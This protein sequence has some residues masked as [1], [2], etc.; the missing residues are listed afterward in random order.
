MFTPIHRALGIEPGAIT[1]DLIDA[2]VERKVEETSDLD[3]KTSLYDPR[4]PNWQDEVAKD[5]A[6][7][8]NSGGGWI[9]FGVAEGGEANG[10]A[11]VTPVE[12]N[13]AAQQ[14]ILQAAYARVGPPVLGL[15]FFPV[16]AGEGH[17]VL[18]RVPDS[19]DAPH[20]ARKGD[21]AFVA[22]RRNGPHTVFMSDREI[23]RSF[24]ERF[25]RSDD[26]EGQLQALFEHAGQGLNP[27][28]GIIIVMAALPKEPVYRANPLTEEDVYRFF[29]KPTLAGLVYRNAQA[30]TRW[31]SSRIRKGFRQWLQ[32]SEDRDS[33]AFRK[34]VHDDGTVLAAYRLGGLTDRSEAA[35]YYPVGEPNHCMSG[36]IESALIDFITTLRA[37]ATES[38]S[39][40]G[41]RVR[42]GLVGKDDE[43]IFVRTTEGGTN[44]LLDADYTEPIH[45]FQPV[46]ADLEP[47]EPMD[48]LLPVVNDLARDVINQGGVKHLKVMAEPDDPVLRQSD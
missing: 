12:W 40:A 27:E 11:Q 37:H 38:Q 18:V 4:K 21:D 31:D 44:F 8:A 9:V 16:S 29:R 1:R 20:F 48:S 43:P 5:V 26:R 3:W 47:L 23:E 13:A 28:Q 35:S 36:D 34:S 45:H 32:R 25:Q 33:R 24:R 42:V 46:T 22:P 10:A 17:V 6:A 7:M 19:P 41:Y 15:E 39:T 30:L 2:A 14:R